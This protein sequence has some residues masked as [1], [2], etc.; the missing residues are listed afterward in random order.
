MKSL[1]I[2]TALVATSFAATAGNY[3]I[4]YEP[5]IATH[6]SSSQANAVTVSD[7]NCNTIMKCL[8]DSEM[9][10]AERKDRLAKTTATEAQPQQK[11]VVQKEVD[12]NFQHIGN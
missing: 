3:G 4:P 8:R 5:N 10:A 12:F 7:T 2:A 6:A 1:L 11:V 9:R